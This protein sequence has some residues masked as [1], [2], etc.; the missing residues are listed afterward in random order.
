VNCIF[1]VMNYLAHAYMSFNEPSILVGNMISDFV[2]GSSKLGYPVNIQKGIMLHREIDA[3]TDAHPATAKAKNF[4]RPYYR[5]YSG[6]ITDIVYD[7]FLATDTNSFTEE[8]LLQ[9]TKGV[10]RTL[11]NETVHLPAYFL[12]VLTYMKMENWLYHYRT[13]EGIQKSLRGL[14]RRASFIHDSTKAIEVFNEHYLELKECY[15]EFF[16]DVKQMAKQK[17]AELLA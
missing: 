6:P 15:E 10:Y 7:H 5:L 13:K 12:P 2:K 16:P 11:E 8:S 4:F 17:F 14:V 1:S 9:F 3:F